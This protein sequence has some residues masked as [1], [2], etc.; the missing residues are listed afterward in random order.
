MLR[1][2]RLALEPAIDAPARPPMSPDEAR[3]AWAR[4]RESMRDL[5]TPRP[6]L[7]EQLEA[8]R[9]DRDRA[10][11]ERH[12]EPDDLDSRHRPGIPPRKPHDCKCFNVDITPCSCVNA[13]GG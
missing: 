7:G 1:T 4:L 13:P 11:L 2:A 12:V 5:P 6:T 3:A 9:R 10:L 8:D